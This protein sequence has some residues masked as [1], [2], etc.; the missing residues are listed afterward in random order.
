MRSGGL[1]SDIRQD[2]GWNPVVAQ[3][4]HQES[5]QW[6]KTI[7]LSTLLDE[8]AGRPFSVQILT[9]TNSGLE[10]MSSILNVKG[11]KEW[12]R[13]PSIWQR[14]YLLEMIQSQWFGHCLL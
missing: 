8:V 9:I 4:L 14:C 7:S 12:P 6:R 5:G 11:L 2:M 1:F 13:H 3:S 10:T